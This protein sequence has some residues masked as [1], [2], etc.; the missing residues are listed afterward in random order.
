MTRE[1][2]RRVILQP[3]FK[4]ELEPILARVPR[5]EE[6][7]SGFVYAVSR[8]PEMG[9]AVQGMPEFYCR[10]FHP[11]G[12]SFLV[13]YKFDDEKVVCVRLRTVP[14]SAF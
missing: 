14:S 9:M 2:P 12:A 11:E 5:A 13:I 4:A 10:P 7:W 8:I 1:S 3:R 6:A